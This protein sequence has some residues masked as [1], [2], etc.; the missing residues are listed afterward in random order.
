MKEKLKLT[1]GTIV[2]IGLT[3]LFH[4][5][6]GNHGLFG[7]MWLFMLSVPV[8]SFLDKKE[9]YFALMWLLF[10]IALLVLYIWI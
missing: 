2:V 10:C 6:W 1:A 8:V 4:H 7:I 9:R 5:W 3:I